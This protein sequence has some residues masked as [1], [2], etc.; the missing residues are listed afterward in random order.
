MFG[1]TLRM[2]LRA[3]K[4]A[5]DLDDHSNSTSLGATVQ[6]ILLN[7]AQSPA[8]KCVTLRVEGDASCREYGGNFAYLKS[9]TRSPLSAACAA[10]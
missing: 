8:I 9:A 10:S 4:P 7:A 3:T 5:S 2:F 1:D 6:F